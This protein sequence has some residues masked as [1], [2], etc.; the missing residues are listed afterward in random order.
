MGYEMSLVKIPE[1]SQDKSNTTAQDEE[2]QD[3]WDIYEM[4]LVKI[5]EDSQDRSN[6]TAQGEELQ[7][8]WDMR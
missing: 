8:T 5:T 4:S 2:L 6:T 3:T 1:D 7:D